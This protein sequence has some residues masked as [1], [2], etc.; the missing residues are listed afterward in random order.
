MH[1]AKGSCGLAP[2][3]CATC[4]LHAC[5]HARCVCPMHAKCPSLRARRMR[6]SHP[7]P[8][9]CPQSALTL[10]GSAHQ[11][12]SAVG[13]APLPPKLPT[14]RCT[15]LCCAAWCSAGQVLFERGEPPDE[16]FIV[17]CGS[18][19]CAVDFMHS[20]AH[21][22]A[23]DQALPPN[24]TARHSDR[25]AGGGRGGMWGC[26]RWTGQVHPLN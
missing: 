19:L 17:E 14:L 2:G 21:S 4:R 3:C 24:L 25:W 22:R 10:R 1:A 15:V 12:H 23:V 9:G 26:G 18:V 7:P 16:I 20:S 5:I 11:V 13:S 6:A 8:W